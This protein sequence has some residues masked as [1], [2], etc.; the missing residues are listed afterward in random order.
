MG[1]SLKESDLVSVGSIVDEIVSD[2]LVVLLELELEV[3]LLL[4]VD[5]DV[6]DG[7]AEA[8]VS[9]LHVRESVADPENDRVS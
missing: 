7:D 4:G 5:V 1:V 9:L 3:R 8:V 2:R 6:V